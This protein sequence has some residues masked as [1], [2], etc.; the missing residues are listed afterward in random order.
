M[1]KNL[2][3]TL[4][5]TTGGFPLCFQIASAINSLIA[6]LRL[7]TFQIAYAILWSTDAGRTSDASSAH[8]LSKQA[9]ADQA[10]EQRQQ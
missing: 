10:N 1:G 8:C 6:R 5:R 7:P 2:V 9:V 3:R 4:G